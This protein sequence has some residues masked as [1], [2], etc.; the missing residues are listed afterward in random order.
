MTTKRKIKMSCG[1]SLPAEEIVSAYQS[2]RASKRKTFSHAGGRPRTDKT[3][4][5][6]CGKYA[7]TYARTI[8]H[9][10]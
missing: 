6:K 7:A 10:C 4:L 8:G 5:C 2:L 1:N 3:K 9:V